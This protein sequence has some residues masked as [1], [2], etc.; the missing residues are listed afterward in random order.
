MIYTQKLCT[1]YTDAATHIFWIYCI[2]ELFYNKII[3][4]M[5]GFCKGRLSLPIMVRSGTAGAETEEEERNRSRDGGVYKPE[6][7]GD[8]DQSLL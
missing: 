5:V 7:R 1:L 2:R 4:S 6:R 3:I 8:R